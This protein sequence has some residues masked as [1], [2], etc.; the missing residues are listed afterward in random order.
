M[1]SSPHELG[2]F[3]HSSETV[4]SLNVELTAGGYM[5]VGLRSQDTRLRQSHI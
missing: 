3:R 4:F 2:L 5:C 1:T